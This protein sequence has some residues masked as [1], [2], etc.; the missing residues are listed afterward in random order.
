MKHGMS[1]SDYISSLSDISQELEGTPDEV[2]E[3]YLIMCIFATLSEQFA[4]IVD[5]LKNRP[6][7]EQTLNSISTILIEH[8]TVQ[9]LRNT[10]TDSN[11]NLA[12]TSSN[13]LS[14]NVNGGKHHQTN[15]KGKHCRKPYNKKRAIS[16]SS[17]ITYYYC[18]R[19]GHKEIGCEV[20]KK[21]TETRQGREDKRGKSASAHRVKTGDTVVHGLT[22]MARVAGH[23]QN[24]RMDNRL[25]RYTPHLTKSDGLS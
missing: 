8:E 10:T 20:K 22:A 7:E 13:A 21:A 4:N 2:T 25:R 15:G 5:I 11:L 9:A 16:D 14:A 23:T 17:N 19:K 12:R 3:R 1:V 24:R 18:T 6:I